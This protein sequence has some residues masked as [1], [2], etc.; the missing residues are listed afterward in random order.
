[1]SG[2]LH[3]RAALSRGNS[4]RYPLDRRLSGLQS[5]SGYCGV[6]KNLLPRLESK[7]DRPVAIARRYIDRGLEA[8]GYL[9]KGCLGLSF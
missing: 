2:Q 7:P 9:H 3:A 8:I 5:R 4:P 6:E 1:M